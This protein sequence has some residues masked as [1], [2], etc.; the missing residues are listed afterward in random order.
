MLLGAQW[1]ILFNVIAGATAI[2]ADLKEVAEV[3]RM[4]RRERWTRLYVPCVF[5]YLVTGLITAAGGAWNATI[6]SEFVQVKDRTFTA[7]GL[8]STISQATAGGNFP[9]LCAAVVTMAVFVVMVNRFFWK[10]LY[11]L[12]EARFS[13][14]V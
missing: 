3:Y 10:R 11:R 14:N 6:V 4:S 8:G 1:Y 7:F 13:L 2:P 12:A 5:P 9:M